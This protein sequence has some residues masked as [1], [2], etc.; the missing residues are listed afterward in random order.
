MPPLKRKVSDVATDNGTDDVRDANSSSKRTI[1]ICS[2]S[3]HGLQ[4]I[5][6]LRE[7]MEYSLSAWC[8]IRSTT[9]GNTAGQE[10]TGTNISKQPQ[11][12]HDPNVSPNTTGANM[13]YI[14]KFKMGVSVPR[15]P[16]SAASTLS[17][18][19]PTPV[20]VDTLLSLLP[21]GQVKEMARQWV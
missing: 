10:A 7:A 1:F 11:R 8:T 14:H 9:S 3:E 13:Q 5:D 6:G 17:G 16:S 21:T 4:S 12:G 2:A 15:Q 20:M 18:I 19:A